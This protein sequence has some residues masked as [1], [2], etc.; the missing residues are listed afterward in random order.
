MLLK[1]RRLLIAEAEKA[2]QALEVA[3]TKSPI[4]RASLIET[5]KLI[6]EAV[7]SIESI[8]FSLRSNDESVGS[9][10]PT[11]SAEITNQVKKE[12][13]TANGSSDHIKVNGSQTSSPSPSS[14]NNFSFGNFSLP[15]TVSSKEFYPAYSNGFGLQTLHLESLMKQSDSTM[16][17]SQP[18]ENGEIIYESFAQGNGLAAPQNSE[19]SPPPPKPS[20]KWIRGRL[21]EVTE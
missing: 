8:E 4:A 18:E 21:V 19:E 2:A 11:V 7:Q 17:L 12:A 20:K 1:L 14:N 3:A 6:A 10:P 13:E 16:Q 5:R 15:D 9:P